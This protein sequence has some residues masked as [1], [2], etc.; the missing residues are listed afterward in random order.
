MEAILKEIRNK[1]ET[2][3]F[4]CL[5]AIAHGAAVPDPGY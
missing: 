3:K 4:Y 2:I 5:H 1:R